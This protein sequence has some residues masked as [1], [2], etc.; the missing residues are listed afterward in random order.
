MESTRYLRTR[1]G[2]CPHLRTF[3][4]LPD[5]TSATGN[6]RFCD[7][8]WAQHLWPVRRRV[9]ITSINQVWRPVWPPTPIQ[10]SATYIVGRACCNL[11]GRACC[12]FLDLTPHKIRLLH[13]ETALV[14]T[15]ELLADPKCNVWGWAALVERH[16][17][18]LRRLYLCLASSPVWQWY[19][20]FFFC[21]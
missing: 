16:L 12:F 6:G 9:C 11:V 7:G 13:L 17:C 10:S 8:N 18:R 20:E 2:F 3:C 4:S 15:S 21:L 19:T 14:L 1:L 5:R